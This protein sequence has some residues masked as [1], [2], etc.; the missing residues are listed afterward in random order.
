MAERCRLAASQDRSSMRFAISAA[1]FSA[2]RPELTVLDGIRPRSARR[3]LRALMGPSGREDDAVEP[4]RGMRRAHQR[5]DAGW[6]ERRSPSVRDGPG[7]MR[8]RT[9]GFIFQFYNLMPVLSREREESVELPLLPPAARAERVRRVGSRSSWWACTTASTTLRASSPAASERWQSRAPSRRPEI[10][11]ARRAHG[12]WTAKARGS[13]GAAPDAQRD[14][15]HDGAD[16]APRSARREAAKVRRRLD[17]G[18]L[19]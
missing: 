3:R 1:G 19:T 15:G 7:A 11:V 14:S 13:A 9:I 17:K 18:Q 16:G 5:I 12:A 8:G 6:R 2:D 4:D 10:I